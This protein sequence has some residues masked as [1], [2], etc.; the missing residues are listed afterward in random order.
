MIQHMTKEDL[1]A[2]LRKLADG[3]EAGDS[4]EGNLSYTCMV[5]DCPAGQ[6]DVWALVRT[7]NASGQG[8]MLILGM[9]VSLFDPVRDLITAHSVELAAHPH[10]YFEL[11]YTRQ[12]EWMAWI[13]SKPQQE[14]PDRKVLANGQGSTPEEACE[15]ALLYYHARPQT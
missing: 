8:G 3:V 10:T 6:F 7:G 11:A 4:F 14:D 15:K 12:T 5:P 2:L 1:A 13:C 9:P